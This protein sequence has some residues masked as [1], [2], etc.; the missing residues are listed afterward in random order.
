MSCHCSLP[1]SGV[2]VDLCVLSPGTA[3]IAV[4]S[5]RLS[6][7]VLCLHRC[8]KMGAAP[9][10]PH[11]GLNGVGAPGVALDQWWTEAERHGPGSAVYQL[12]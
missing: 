1:L 3:H 6:G 9:P 4:V 8:K 12:G 7:I 10:Q 2:A 5:V 11:G